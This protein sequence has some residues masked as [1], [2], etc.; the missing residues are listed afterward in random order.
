MRTIIAV[1]KSNTL[2]GR[3]DTTMQRPGGRPQVEFDHGPEA[4]AGRALQFA[5]TCRGG[6]HIAAPPEVAAHIPADM[7]SRA[8]A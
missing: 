2:P 6:F 3:Y 7:R 4:A 1:T 5:A 8:E